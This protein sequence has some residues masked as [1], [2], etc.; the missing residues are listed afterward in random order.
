MPVVGVV[1]GRFVELND[2]HL[3]SH[4]KV[5]DYEQSYTSNE[6]RKRESSHYFKTVKTIIHYL[7]PGGRDS[8]FLASTIRD[9]F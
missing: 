8:F 7:V 4:R 1:K 5:G 2:R 9:L 6:L 3:R